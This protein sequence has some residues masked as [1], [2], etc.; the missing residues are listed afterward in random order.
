[1]MKF[2][3]F[4]K[5]EASL[6]VPYDKYFDLIYL[7]KHFLEARLSPNREF[8]ARKAFYGC[9]RRMAVEKAGL[10]YATNLKEVLG[11]A[12][13]HMTINDPAGEV[14]YE[15]GFACNDLKNKFLDDE[16]IERLIEESEG[17]LTREVPLQ[18]SLQSPCSVRRVRRR[19]KPDLRLGEDFIQSPGGTIYYLRRDCSGSST[20]GGKVNKVKLSSKSILKAHK[21]VIRRG[22]NK[23]EKFD[24][25]RKCTSSI[26]SSSTMAA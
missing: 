21:E 11:P 17:D 3:D 16:T 22:L 8:I 2:N 20:R 14:A 10:W 6:R 7:T 15:D 12:H 13:L 18:D 1:M 19:R 26:G 4:Q 23:F 5:Y 9:N 24:P 25:S